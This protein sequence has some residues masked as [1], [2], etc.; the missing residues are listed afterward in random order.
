MQ[1]DAGGDGA[2]DEGLTEAVLAEHDERD[3]ALDASAAARV[4][5]H[6]TIGRAD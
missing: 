5:S 3:G 6:G 1:I 4:F 2:L